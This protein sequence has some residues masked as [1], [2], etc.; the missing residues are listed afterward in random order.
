MAL[1]SI[2][3]L[4][5]DILP[6]DLVVDTPLLQRFITKVYYLLQSYSNLSDTDVETESSYTAKQRILI[7]NY[8]AFLYLKK[9]LA[10]NS[11]S[12]KAADGSISTNAYNSRIKK[13]KA[14]VV[15]VEFKYA[16]ESGS[17][18]Y[19]FKAKATEIMGMCLMDL[20]SIA[21]ELE[22]RLQICA[23]INKALDCGCGDTVN[24]VFI[25]PC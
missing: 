8:S 22:W 11:V 6:T 16:D 24:P 7:A 9:I 5:T 20:C 1:A 15:E 13:S 4:A 3:Q 23:E 19:N 2:E 12:V 18:A 21:R 25:L 17:V 14:D 10:D